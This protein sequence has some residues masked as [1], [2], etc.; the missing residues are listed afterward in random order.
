M[1]VYYKF[2]S[3]KDYESVAFDGHFISVGDLKAI[4][5]K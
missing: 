1:A 4:Y 3:A 2:K 5:M